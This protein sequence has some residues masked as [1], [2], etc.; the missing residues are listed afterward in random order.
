MSW[1]KSWAQNFCPSNLPSSR[2]LVRWRP[3]PGATPNVRTAAAQPN[4]CAPRE[5]YELYT[6]NPS[7]FHRY[8]ML[9]LSDGLSRIDWSNEMV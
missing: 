4:R 1:M 2:G 8:K 3:P 7:Q 5:A 9:R 6:S